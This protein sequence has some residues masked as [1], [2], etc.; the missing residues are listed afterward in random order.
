[1]LALLHPPGMSGDGATP[2]SGRKFIA[3]IET[4]MAECQS[5]IMSV[6]A[7]DACASA[8]AQSRYRTL[9]D[10][11]VEYRKLERIDTD[12]DDI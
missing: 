2:M 9:S 5:S 12:E 4:L 6:Q 1:M 8:K 7:T 10:V 11:L 3:R